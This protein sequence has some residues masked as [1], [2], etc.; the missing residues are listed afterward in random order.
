MFFYIFLR[1]FI[2]LVVL[3]TVDDKNHAVESKDNPQIDKQSGCE[4]L[5]VNDAVISRN[6]SEFNGICL[7]IMALPGMGIRIDFQDDNSSWSIYDLFYIQLDK[8]C[9]DS[10]IIALTGKPKT[11]STLFNTSDLEIYS[12]ASLTVD[13]SSSSI[14]KSFPNPVCNVAAIGDQ[15]HNSQPC[16]NLANFNRIYNFTQE[17][18]PYSELVRLHPSL[19][20]TSFAD[21]WFQPSELPLLNLAST[22]RFFSYNDEVVH[23]VCRSTKSIPFF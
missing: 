1:V 23:H 10:R 19:D 6:M 13:F 20:F 3:S 16:T 9:K 14:Y 11:C 4:P 17:I 5:N 8:N 21:V 7:H 12:H 2:V 22:G 15:S 18:I